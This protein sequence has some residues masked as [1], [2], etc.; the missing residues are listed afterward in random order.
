[1]VVAPIFTTTSLKGRYCGHRAIFQST[2]ANNLELS[3]LSFALLRVV[4]GLENWRHLFNQS[5]AKLKPITTW[6]P[7]FL[8]LWLA[9][10]V[11]FEFSLVLKGIFL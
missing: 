6:S 10:L 11:C 9:W 4:I 1:M 5:D 3:Q 2:V 8:V 7:A